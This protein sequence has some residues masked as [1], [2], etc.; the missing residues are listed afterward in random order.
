MTAVGLSTSNSGIVGDACATEPVV[1]DSSYFPSTAG[2]M[3]GTGQRGIPITGLCT[4]RGNR[5]TPRPCGTLGSPVLITG[6][7][8][9]LRV[10]VIVIEVVAG[11][12]VLGVRC[13]CEG[14]GQ[15]VGGGGPRPG[16]YQ[17]T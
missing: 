14:L 8:S 10:W 2:P 1:S 16:P 5:A 15:A 7:V 13:G 3:P 9:R 6:R 11:Q 17:L 12:G 4:P